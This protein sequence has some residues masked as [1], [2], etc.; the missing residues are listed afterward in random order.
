MDYVSNCPVFATDNQR[1]LS[2]CL[3]VSGHDELLNRVQT[4][5]CFLDPPVVEVEELF[6]LQPLSLRRRFLDIVFLNRILHRHLYSKGY[7]VEEIPTEKI[8]ALFQCLQLVSPK[9]PP[10]SQR[11]GL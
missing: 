5:I 2:L 6:G 1:K 10:Q 9:T 3:R 4:W 11:R 7:K 8:Y